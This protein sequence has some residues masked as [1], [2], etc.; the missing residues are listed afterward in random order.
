MLP[1]KQLV[2]RAEALLQSWLSDEARFERPQPADGEA[3]ADLIVHRGRL[4]LVVEVK[5]TV[6]AGRLKDAVEQT[7]AFARRMGANA[8]PVVVVPFM[9]PVGRRL[10]EEARI[11]WFDLSGNADINA[12]GLRIYVEGKPNL[13]KRRGRP[14]TVFAPK[15]SR[16]VRRLLLQPH[17]AFQQRELARA[18]R[19]DEGFTSRIV[20]KLEADRMI[21][22]G[23]DGSLRVLDPDLLLDSWRE[24]SDFSKHYVVPG[25]V[26]ARSGEEVLARMA[27]TL[28]KKNVGYAATGLAAAWMLTR[29]ATFRLGTFYVSEEPPENLL[30]EVGFR[31]EER[32]ANIWL[33]V[34]NDDD[35]FEGAADQKGIRCA[36]PVQVYLDLKGHPERSA[37]AAEELRKRYLRWRT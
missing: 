25:H 4:K 22:R 18:S 15:S 37:E 27:A 2:R 14:A 1:E 33:V 12:A 29:F 5:R 17:R 7:R 13:F 35:V 6:D 19:L 30:K 10:C 34:P 36:H 26:T 28:R 8:V 23:D 16:V 9:G 3:G 32:G 11:S 21:R 31:R 24:S 20:K